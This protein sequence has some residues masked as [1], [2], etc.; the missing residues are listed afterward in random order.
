MIGEQHGK[1]MDFG[2]PAYLPRIIENTFSLSGRFSRFRGRRW[3]S[4]ATG[5]SGDHFVIGLQN[6]DHAGNRALGERTGQLLTPALQRLSAAFLL[7]S[8]YLP[9]IFMGEEYG[10]DRP[11][12][13][14]CSF[15]DEGLIENVRSGRKRDYELQG[16]I[17][18][19]QAPESYLRSKISWSWPEGTY[20][21]GLRLLYQDLLQARKSWPALQDFDYRTARLWPNDTM[22]QLLFMV[23]G[24]TKSGLIEAIFNLTDEIVVLERPV[25]VD[26]L[27]MQ[28]ESSRYA[29][30]NEIP[31]SEHSVAPNLITHIRP[32]EC[33]VRSMPV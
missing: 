1:Y 9:L 21:H 6:H 25:E 3:G 13:F 15:E 18:D 24:D 8:P 30:E 20:R 17:P 26:A 33:I 28:T 29:P 7:L 14:F 22:P 5:I 19:P 4:D 32:Y 23:R 27:L 31:H 11:F 16:E 12:L 10:E 2:D